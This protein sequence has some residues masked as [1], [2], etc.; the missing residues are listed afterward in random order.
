MISNCTQKSRHAAISLLLEQRLHSLF[1]DV[2]AL[3]LNKSIVIDSLQSF[4]IVTGMSAADVKEDKNFRDGF[5]I[6]K[7]I[8]T[9]V[10]YIVLF[11]EEQKNHRRRAFTIAHEIG[12]IY[13]GHKNDSHEN[14]IEANRF[15][16][17]LLMPNIILQ[18]YVKQC[19]PSVNDICRVFNV[20][21]ITAQ[22][23][24]REISGS[25]CHCEKCNELLRKFAGLLP[26]PDGPIITF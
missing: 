5:T 10:K 23:R 4:C 25:K 12:H 24:L 13:L 1:I 3:R 14:E 19:S 21:Q 22:T 18:E 20:S 9:K 6:I 26:F 16:S 15:A 2:T 8:G 11:N 17:E 7:G